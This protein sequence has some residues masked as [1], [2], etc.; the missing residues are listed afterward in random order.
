MLRTRVRPTFSHPTL[1]GTVASREQRLHLR[2]AGGIA[3][4]ATLDPVR[5][6]NALT[7]ARGNLIDVEVTRSALT[8]AQEPAACG[9]DGRS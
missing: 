9:D 6:L 5:M 4:G 8:D 1:S 7:R 2:L 3:L